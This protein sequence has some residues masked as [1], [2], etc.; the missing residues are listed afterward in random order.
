MKRTP[1]YGDYGL[2]YSLAILSAP[3]LKASAAACNTNAHPP[4]FCFSQPSCRI[5]TADMLGESSRFME[6]KTKLYGQLFRR[7]IKL[8]QLQVPIIV[9]NPDLQFS[10]LTT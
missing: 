10:A 2:T 7:E 6:V 9:W 5:H 8:L 1:V 3:T 4:A